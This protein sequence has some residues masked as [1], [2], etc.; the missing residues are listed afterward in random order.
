METD[1]LFQAV[2]YLSAAVVF[3]P[4]AKKLGMSS[5]LG[6][7]LAGIIIGPFVLGLIGQEGHDIMRFA[8]FGIVMMLFLIG[9]EMEPGKSWK[10]RKIFFGMGSM[11]LFGT[12]LIVFMGCILFMDWNWKTTLAISS[13]LAL[14]SSAIVLQSL[15]EKG[16]RNTAL[17]Q[18]SFA[19]LLFQDIAVIPILVFLPILATSIPNA[20]HDVHQSLISSF[21]GWI[22]A[23]II[24]GI[25]SLIYFGGRFLFVL[26]FKI[27]AKTRLQELFTASALLLVVSI[28]CLMHLIGISPALGTFLSGV[29]LAN[30]EFR[31][32]LE[33]DI[34]PFKG[35]LL[36]LF[37]IGVGASINFQLVMDNPLFILVFG[38]VLTFIKFTVSFLISRFYKK[39]TEENTLF[40]LG[41]SQSGEFGFVI[42][43]FCIQLNIVPTI[44]ANQIMAIIAMSMVSTPFLQ[45]INERFMLQNSKINKKESEEESAII[46]E[47]NPVIIAGF[48]HFGSTVGRLLRANKI[49]STILDNDCDQ[50]D[51]LRKMGFKAHYGDATRLELLEAAGCANAKLF[52]AA[53]DNPKTNLSIIETLRVHF[54]NLKI[55]TRARNRID[56]YE[57]IDYKIA[58]IYRETL[59]SAVN[60]GIDVLVELGYRKYTATRQATQ[61]IKN[62]EITT[63]KLAKKRYNKMAY[64]TTINAEIKWLEQLLKNDLESQKAA[65]NHSWDSEHLKK[66]MAE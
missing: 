53:I 57:L 11:Q 7:L 28:S 6:Y 10:I 44:L 47:H 2:I 26:L 45:F 66:K 46:N 41:L 18:S 19:V 5:I 21:P 56:A 59:Y 49:K 36:G 24:V 62:D 20:A 60:M 39:K 32:E 31:H 43:S 58:H 30:S 52:I 65:N 14:S 63:R 8:E 25:I 35:L 29:V 38:A 40:A 54:P 27:I 15:S 13:T 17:G 64:L 50:I 42:M 9:L 51:F 23:G 22:Q 4:I 37:F 12:I 33:G 1:F 48:G 34:A 3:V 61:F 55:L 16:L